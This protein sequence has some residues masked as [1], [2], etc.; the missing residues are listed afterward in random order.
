[1]R[2]CSLFR[3]MKSPGRRQL[4]V[5]GSV[6]RKAFPVYPAMVLPLSLVVLHCVA[7]SP[8]S[9]ENGELKI[10]KGFFQLTAENA[11]DIARAPFKP[12]ILEPP[13]KEATVLHPVEDD[14][15]Q[16]LGQNGLSYEYLRQ[17]WFDEDSNEGW[18]VGWPAVILRYRNQRWAE[19]PGED[20]DP[21]VT[22]NT[23]W[24][25]EGARKG[26]AMGSRGT[27]L[28][29]DGR[30]WQNYSSEE[31]SDKV[32]ISSL[33]LNGSGS[34]GW[35]VGQVDT[36]AERGASSA[37]GR[38][39]GKKGIV[40]ELRYGSHWVPYG[41]S[42]YFLR[43]GS[44]T[45]ENPLIDLWMNH[46]G[47]EGWAVGE[48]SI[49]LRYKDGGWV[50]DSGSMCY[51]FVFCEENIYSVQMIQEGQRGWAAG[52]DG[53]ILYFDGDSW[54]IHS[55]LGELS[56]HSLWVSEDGH[57]G[58]A[59]G[60]NGSVF[61]LRNGRWQQ[62]LANSALTA[63]NITSL[64]MSEDGSEGWAVAGGG[65]V[66]RYDAEGWRLYRQETFS[67]M[68]IGARAE[69][70]WAVGRGGAISR[71]GGGRWK[72]ELEASSLT[73]ENLHAIWMVSDGSE[74]WIVGDG[75]VILRYR[76]SAWR[77][78][79][80][81]PSVRN[82][83]ALWFSSDGT[84]GWA[85][86]NVSLPAIEL[87]AG[88]ELVVMRFADQSWERSRLPLMRRYPE[89]T[90]EAIWI[91]PEN[92]HGWAVGHGGLI[93]QYC[94][95]YWFEYISSAI[96]SKTPVTDFNDLWLRR[97]GQ[98]GWAVSGD[99]LFEY[100]DSRW[101]R[102]LETAYPLKAVW[103]RGRGDLCW[104][105]GEDEH[106]IRGKMLRYARGFW[107]ELGEESR[108]A[109]KGLNDVWLT[110]A[111]DEGWALGEAGSIL[112]YGRQPVGHAEIRSESQA[113]LMSLRGSHELLLS[114]P[115]ESQPAI[116]LQDQQGVNR[117]A[118]DM[119]S[120]SEVEKGSGSF[121]IDFSSVPETLRRDL[122]GDLCKLRI[123]I[124]RGRASVPF[125]AVYESEVFRFGTS[126]RPRLV[127]QT[128][129]A[130]KIVD[131][132]FSADGKQILTASEDGTASLWD[133]DSGRQIVRYVGHRRG[134]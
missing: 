45:F 36:I 11:E 6:R 129:H 43:S 29:Y 74:G 69:Q 25:N 57:K 38:R 23:I 20:L 101:R 60:S 87:E 5:A 19:E 95:G 100:R 15:L 16:W 33:W 109:R 99:G 65:T 49:I 34:R 108:I 31:I 133:R 58:W 46:G 56:I 48:G 120:V 13:F 78:Y 89:V 111:G 79:Q 124:P 70:G 98:T 64:W 53:G 84:E 130:G 22:I 92:T 62:D 30:E 2:K 91:S 119:Y 10:K 114:R 125:S 51:N 115:G 97:D 42:T 39:H 102:V 132:E 131:A 52:S 107:Q 63:Q 44:T 47:T 106:G 41:A 68:W 104:A 82:L 83:R 122:R 94:D 126:F 93:L 112:R 14:H 50:R 37:V 4:D 21:G 118:S 1:M 55:R 67:A 12:E 123:E 59:V 77:L 103:C 75:G 17:I 72:A 96:G 110:E 113:D 26:W 73:D 127:L 66:L 81:D 86:A 117:L 71:L 27:I 121:Q 90:V 3:Q 40:L 105:V 7:L 85:I 76:G 32:H 61:F 54:E 8:F 35:A 116:E 88:S 28:W 134:L 80:A 9:V 24:M 128:G 18:A